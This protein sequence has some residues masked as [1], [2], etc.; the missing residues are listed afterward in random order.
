[1]DPTDVEFIR[2][3]L[4]GFELAGEIP[5][6]REVLVAERDRRPLIDLEGPPA[7]AVARMLDTL[8][9]G[10]P[11]PVAAEPPEEVPS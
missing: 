10:E 9:A 3:R 11:V 8:A 2:E 4:P 1:V 7:V 6:S 5:F